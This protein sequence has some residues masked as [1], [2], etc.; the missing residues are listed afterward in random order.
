MFQI[1][2]GSINH[3]SV[4]ILFANLIYFPWESG[5]QIASFED[6]D[7]VYIDQIE[8]CEYE[9]KLAIKSADDID[10]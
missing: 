4:F 2:Y 10:E 7:Q 8:S 6:L 1:K 5:T 9:M 3:K